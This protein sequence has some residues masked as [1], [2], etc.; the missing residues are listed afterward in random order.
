MKQFS[1]RFE[2]GF[3]N[4]G[5]FLPEVRL[6]QPQLVSEW[7]ASPE[8]KRVFIIGARE[9]KA[10]ISKL[11]ESWKSDG[12]AVFFYDFCRQANGELCSEQAV[13]A[14]FGTSGFTFVYDTLAARKSPYVPVEIATA[15]HLAGVDSRAYLISSSELRDSISDG[16]QF[17]MY[18]AEEPAPTPSPAR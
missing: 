6:H 10:V 4:P 17:A 13:G 3:R 18:M 5:Q 16:V 14:M 11:A 8:E 2:A 12:Y 15:R 1:K 7:L 9:D